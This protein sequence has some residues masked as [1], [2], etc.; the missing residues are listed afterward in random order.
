MTHFA[1][2]VALSFSKCAPVRSTGR[3]HTRDCFRYRSPLSV[4]RCTTLSCNILDEHSRTAANS[5]SVVFVHAIEL[6][7]TRQ[8]VAHYTL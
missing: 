3:I 6:I 5:A 4:Y 2:R 1:L 7:E 8:G